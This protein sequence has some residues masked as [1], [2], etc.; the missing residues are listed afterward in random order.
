M[1]VQTSKYSGTAHFFPE[2]GCIDVTLDLNCDQASE[3]RS[4]K[5]YVIRSGREETT[6]THYYFLSDSWKLQFST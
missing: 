5:E 3:F 6:V 1:R 4:K 2:A